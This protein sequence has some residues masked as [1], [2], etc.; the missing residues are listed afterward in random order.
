MVIDVDLLAR[1]L[2]LLDLVL[3]AQ[4]LLTQDAE[5]LNGL[6]EMLHAIHAQAAAGPV[7]ILRFLQPGTQREW[8]H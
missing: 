2:M 3:R 1:Q 4:H 7:T 8:T 6:L 5:D